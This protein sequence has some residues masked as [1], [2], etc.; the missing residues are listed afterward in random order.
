MIDSLDFENF[1]LETVEQSFKD[2]MKKMEFQLP[3][4]LIIPTTYF[5]IANHLASKITVEEHN[6]IFEFDPRG[7]GLLSPKV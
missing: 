3:E 5:V 4:K 1:S 6:L 7:F 2:M